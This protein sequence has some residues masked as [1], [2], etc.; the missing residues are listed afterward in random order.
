MNNFGSVQYN[1]CLFR[2]IE[3]YNIV[4]WTIKFSISSS[5]IANPT[6]ERNVF[7]KSERIKKTVIK[8]R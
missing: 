2:N 8:I 3:V 6:G 7:I 4:L 5:V 1:I